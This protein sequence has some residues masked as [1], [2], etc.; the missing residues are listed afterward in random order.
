[1]KR[2]LLIT[3]M[4]T[5]S[6][7]S[8][9]LGFIFAY[10]L[11]D[12]LIHMQKQETSKI[13]DHHGTIIYEV[14]DEE[15]GRTTYVPLKEISKHV[16]NAAVASEDQDFYNHFGV[17][18]WAI[19]RAVWL[20]IEAGRIV[21]GGSTIPQQLI[22]NL[23]QNK[24]RG[25]IPKIQETIY[26]IKLHTMYSKE[27][28]LEKY[29]NTIYFGNLAYGIEAA[30]QTYFQKN[31]SLLDVA[32]SS[33]LIGL[34]QSPGRYDPYKHEQRAKKRQGTV[35]KRMVEEGMI[36]ESTK[37]ASNDQKLHLV[38]KGKKKSGSHFVDHILNVMSHENPDMNLKQGNYR[39][40]TTLNND[41][42]KT[43]QQ[44]IGKKLERLRNHKVS[45]A[46]VVVLENATGA[47]RVML[48][49]KDYFD[50]ESGNFNVAFAKRQPGSSIKP[51]V[52]AQSFEEGFY[53]GTIIDDTQSKFYTEEGFPYYPKNFDLK[54]H[55][56][57]SFREALGSSLNIPAVK[58]LQEMGVGKVMQT[59]QKMGINTFT[60]SKEHYGLALALGGGE[61]K[62]IEL[63]QAYMA[64][65]NEGMSLPL[66][67][68]EKIQACNEQEKC[69]EIEINK[70]ETQKVLSRETAFMIT[71]VLKDNKA[72]ILSFGEDNVL[73]TNFESA[74]KTGTS[75]NFRDNWTLGYSR[76]YTV[77]VWVGN[78]DSS[79]MKEVSGITGAGP[80]W[81][82]VMEAVHKEHPPKS[83]NMPESMERKE[84]CHRDKCWSEVV[85]KGKEYQQYLE[86][87]STEKK[88][89]LIIYPLPFDRFFLDASV[90]GEGQRMKLEAREE[91][92]WEI[93]GVSI[94]TG[95]KVFWKMT[96]GEHRIRARRE[97]GEERVRVFVEG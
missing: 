34:I 72:R 81:R 19:L 94:G 47:V 5:I 51:I 37:D 54:Y 53:P 2:K 26:A 65:A 18:V 78:N 84:V 83:F 70:S 49:S 59:A 63:C 33:F 85:E 69:E 96:E 86:T 1:M 28:M 17:D 61:V 56:D 90:S 42:Q 50:E 40:T 52:Y 46:S 57:V 64:L 79:P 95:V 74:V 11:P 87:E 14:L 60:Q 62:L 27:E 8:I 44:I 38:P 7:I 6:L 68:I 97:G 29:L 41:L 75:R 82:R 58:V 45:N 66:K 35:L 91:V 32:E 55:G 30:A 88:E 21:S 73:N 23:L 77:C 20:N 10:P 67:W 24:E 4:I 15:K 71:D 16:I 13:Y 93:D 80:I 48:G 36:D 89:S 92:E 22:K 3:G 12:Q 25:L 9:L 76:D 39:I 31:A 43:V